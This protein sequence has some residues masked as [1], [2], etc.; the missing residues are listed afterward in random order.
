[1]RVEVEMTVPELMRE[2]TTRGALGIG[3]GLLLANAFS[4]ASQRS[5]VGW[6]LLGIGGLTGASL[7]YEFFGRPRSF[8]LAFGSPSA[9]SRSNVRK[10]LDMPPAIAARGP[11]FGES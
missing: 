6:T 4:S 1:M 7:A 11:R 8:T 2:V 9:E 10:E 5:A 3:L